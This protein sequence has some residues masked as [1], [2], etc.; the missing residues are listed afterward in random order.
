MYNLLVS[1]D[2][3]AWGGNNFNIEISR[4]INKNEYTDEDLVEQYGKL[5]S[6]DIKELKKFPC[7]FAYEE[8]C[9]MNP[10]FG[11][12][13]QIVKGKVSLEISYEIIELEKF[14]THSDILKLKFELGIPNWEMSRTH[15][16][17]KEI[18]LTSVLQAK[19]IKLPA[20]NVNFEST[21]EAVKRIDKNKKKRESKRRHTLQVSGNENVFFNSRVDGSTIV[22]GKRNKFLKIKIGNSNKKEKSKNPWYK[23]PSVMLPLIVAI[24]SIPWWPS[25]L[26]MSKLSYRGDTQQ[27]SSVNNSELTPTEALPSRNTSSL[28]ELE[29]LETNKDISLLPT[30]I[31]GFAYAFNIVR[32]SK[33]TSDGLKVSKIADRYK[34][35]IHKRETGIYVVGYI[36][37]TTFSKLG[38]TNAD[39]PL[40]VTMYPTNFRGGKYLI[41]VPV[42][43]L[44]NVKDRDIEVASNSLETISILE[45]EIISIGTNEE[46]E[47]YR[48]DVNSL[49]G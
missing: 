1:A 37:E 49:Q 27:S 43:S 21:K 22:G 15:W 7:I 42:N 11:Y 45:A 30:G 14:L 4:C 35:E 33:T 8:S 32:F 24:I 9:Q 16:A 36:D 6:S 38:E 29:T 26:Q 40:K 20:Q 28:R 39:N 19:E 48:V 44:K 17:L 23:N 25:V 31:Y 47:I 46:P 12:I 5:N 41:S 34:F 10:K 2:K 18:E 3:N 13:K